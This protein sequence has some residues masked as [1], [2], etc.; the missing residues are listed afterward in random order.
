[1]IKSII[2]AILFDLRHSEY[3]GLATSTILSKAIKQ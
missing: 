2:I 3:G 1:M